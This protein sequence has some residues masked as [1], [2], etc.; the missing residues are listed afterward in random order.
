MAGRRKGK[1]EKIKGTKNR[2]KMNLA[3]YEGKGKEH[4]HTIYIKVTWRIRKAKTDN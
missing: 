2:G 4:T 3:D 1:K